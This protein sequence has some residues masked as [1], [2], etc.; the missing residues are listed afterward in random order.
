M[1]EGAP[2]HLNC[3]LQNEGAIGIFTD[4][5]ESFT[6]GGIFLKS[7]SPNQP[8][9]VIFEDDGR[10]GYFYLAADEEDMPFQD[11]LH[12]YDLKAIDNPNENHLFEIKWTANGLKAAL[13]INGR[14][15][16]VF[17]LEEKRGYCRNSFPP[18]SSRTAFGRFERSWH[19]NCC[20]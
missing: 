16:G 5:K 14:A 6:L 11:A 15:H 2:T 18:P 13:F 12:I 3:G 1:G 17:D 8:F 19:P 10:T 20:P 9:Y 7:H 4:V